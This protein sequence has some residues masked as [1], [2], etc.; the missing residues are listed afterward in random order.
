MFVEMF[1]SHHSFLHLAS[2]EPK[3]FMKHMHSTR[4]QKHEKITQKKKNTKT[5]K[6][7]KQITQNKKKKKE[8]IHNNKI[9]LI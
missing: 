5:K 9:F 4:K 7:D 8:N 2:L 6:H 1:A 3:T